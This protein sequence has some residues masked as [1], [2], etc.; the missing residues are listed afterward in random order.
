MQLN[1]F[2]RQRD[3][4]ATTLRSLLIGAVVLSSAVCVWDQFTATGASVGQDQQLIALALF[5]ASLVAFAFLSGLGE[6]S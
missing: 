5:L 6:R 4:A 1:A 2:P 3:Y